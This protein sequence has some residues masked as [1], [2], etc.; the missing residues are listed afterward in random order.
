M[1]VE[2]FFKIL[3]VAERLGTV[4]TGKRSLSSVNPLMDEKLC[5]S[6]A[7]LAAIRTLERCDNISFWLR[8]FG[9]F[10]LAMGLNVLDQFIKSSADFFAD[11]A[12]LF[13]VGIGPM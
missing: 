7:T 12:N 8:R 9:S 6:V 10:G 3:T 4:W 2:M 11:N 5:F 13:S 1:T